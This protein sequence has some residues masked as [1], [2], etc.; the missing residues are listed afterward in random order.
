MK[1]FT[2]ILLITIVASSAVNLLAQVNIKKGNTIAF[3]RNNDIWLM[4]SDGSNQRPF[5]TALTNARGRMSWSPDNK[6]IAFARRGELAVRYPDG[7]GHNHATYDLFF[8]YT[9]S[10]K[11]FWEGITNTLGAQL[12]EF[13]RDGSRVMFLNDQNANL[14]TATLPKYRITFW[15]TKTF[16]M[17]SLEMAASSELMV[18]APTLSPDGQ[19][20]AFVVMRLQ[21]EQ[22][23]PAGIAV[24]GI[25]EFPLSDEALL[26]RAGKWKGAGSPSWSP[27]GKWIAYLASDAANPG[28]SVASPDGLT[29]RSL[30]TPT[31]PK[32][33]APQGPPSWS[34]DSKFLVFG[35]TG[36]SI[37]K[38]PVGGGDP[39]RLSGP[40][41]D[42]NPAWSN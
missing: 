27:D 17:R 1:R 35:T 8:A 25:N 15:D 22:F 38:I 41:T 37:Y 34:P 29:K 28:L 32:E 11:G 16:L 4:D 20:V 3:I 10:V 12:P 33:M 23:T 7:G 9:D 26:E 40:G 19:R 5:V 2:I 13:M 14:G 39:V 24:A 21:G 42:Y 30:F 6:K 31:N 36:G 18:S